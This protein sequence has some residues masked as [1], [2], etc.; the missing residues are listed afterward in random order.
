MSE[1]FLACQKLVTQFIEINL[2]ISVVIIFVAFVQFLARIQKVTDAL[3][4]P[5]I[6]A[7][8]L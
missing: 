1:D 5:D 7:R 4:G 2:L 6:M 8:G 3:E